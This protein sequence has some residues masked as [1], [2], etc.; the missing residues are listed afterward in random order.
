MKKQLIIKDSNTAR[1]INPFSKNPDPKT[2]SG[3]C[4]VLSERYNA[5]TRENALRKWQ[6]AESSLKEYKIEGVRFGETGLMTNVSFPIGSIHTFE[7]NEETL[8]CEML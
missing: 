6:Q 2:L 1:E 4:S 7:T 5:Q 8:T 3:G